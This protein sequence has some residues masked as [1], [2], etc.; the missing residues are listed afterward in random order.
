MTKAWD[1]VARAGWRGS[2]PGVWILGLE[3]HVNKRERERLTGTGAH[4]GVL[5]VE[6]GLGVSRHGCRGLMERTKRQE[7]GIEGR[8]SRSERRREE[9]TKWGCC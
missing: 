4:R 1:H 6:E 9:G 7:G 8:G 2:P 5:D 3:E